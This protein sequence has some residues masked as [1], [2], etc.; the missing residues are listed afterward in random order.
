M[1]AYLHISANLLAEWLGKLLLRTTPDWWEECVMEKL[2][3][4][5]RETV[6]S[7]CFTNL[8]DFDL[9]SLLRIADRSWYT[10]REAAYLPARVRECIRDM[11]RVRNN[12]AH[13]SAMLPGKDTILEDLNTLH[14]FFEQM[15]CDDHLIDEVDQMIEAVKQPSTIDF[16]ALSK[17]GSEESTSDE[18]DDENE[19]TEKS[20]VYLIGD[21]AVHGV[22]ISI[23][24]LGDVKKYDVFV[25]GKIRT[26]CG[27][28]L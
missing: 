17:S 18:P 6:K 26:F 19:I 15:K 9:A 14:Q 11:M 1:N 4:N 12:W 2:S 16:D 23:T 5:Q 13:C 8:E 20:L 21:P 27:F 7:K 10:M 28:L 22:V 25:D 3:Y 24:D